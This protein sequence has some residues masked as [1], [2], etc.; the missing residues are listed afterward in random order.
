MI[1]DYGMTHGTRPSPLFYVFPWGRGIPVSPS[2]PCCVRSFRMRLGVG[3]LPGPCK[4]PRHQFILWIAIL[5]RLSTLDK[6][7]LHHLGGSCVLCQDGTLESHDHLFFMCRFTRNFL[8][9]IRR[10]V[11]FYWPNRAWEDDIQWA[12]IRWRGKH[13]VNASY[14]ALLASFVYHLWQ[15]RN[16]RIFQHTTSTYSAVSHCIIS[17]IR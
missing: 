6:P 13:I 8:K 5:G 15:E 4:I 16:R 12:S 1:F 17:D 7:W 14:R 3:R 10:V 11:R 2:R 9:E